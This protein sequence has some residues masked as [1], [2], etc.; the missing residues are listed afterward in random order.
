MIT[1][2]VLAATRLDADEYARDH[3]LDAAEWR[4]IHSRAQLMGLKPTDKH[5]YRVVRVNGHWL[6]P[7]TDNIEQELVLR[8]IEA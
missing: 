2:L 6:H 3:K 5:Q 8:G 4:Y 7:E 1:T